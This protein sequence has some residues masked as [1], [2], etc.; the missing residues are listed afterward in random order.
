[1]LV[2]K[3]LRLFL[4]DAVGHGDEAFLRHQI[5]DGFLRIAG[6]ADVAVGENADE[7]AGVRLN[8][9]DAR[10]AVALH[11]R[12]SFGERCI[13]TDGDGVHHH[14][15]FELLHLADLLGLRLGRHVAMEN[16]DAACLRHGDG[17]AGFRHRVHGSGNDGNAELDCAGQAGA[18]VGLCWQDRGGSR[19]QENVVERQCFTD[20]AANLLGR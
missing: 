3:A 13:R 16:A 6:E 11:F 19:Q 7:L 8:D 14:A 10:N 5:A 17:K 1:M 18:R 15:A 12:E 9:G 2:E 4:A 20:H